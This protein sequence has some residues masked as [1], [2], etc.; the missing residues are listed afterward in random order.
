MKKSFFILFLLSLCFH[1]VAW[2]SGGG[3]KIISYYELILEHFGL[4][5][6]SIHEWVPAIGGMVT[7]ILLTL[8]GFV[9]KRRVEAL[10]ENVCPDGTFSIRTIVDTILDFIADLAKTIIGEHHYR[11]FLPLLCGLFLFI[12]VSNLTGLIPGFVPSTESINTNL[13]MG[14]SVF[15]VYNFAGFKE[16]GSHY[17]KQFVGP[18]VFLMPLMII[19]E[20]VAHLARP[21]SLSLRLYGNIFGD[22]LVLSVFTGLTY[23]V[24][25]A[26]LLF[27]GLLVASLQS[28]VFTLLSSIYISMAMSHDH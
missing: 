19:I 8:I 22:H 2:A 12:F 18:V 28:F 14:L 9:Y 15:L 13:A 26:F 23:L 6:H 7:L 10:G 3:V 24:F 21:V 11:S 27:F 25:P 1:S 20:L 5:E 4:D 17:L 16:H